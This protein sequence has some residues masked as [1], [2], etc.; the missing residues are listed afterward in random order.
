MAGGKKKKKKSG[1]SLFLQLW[2]TFSSC[3]YAGRQFGYW[4]A[5]QRTADAQCCADIV[6]LQSIARETCYFIFPLVSLITFHDV[7][8]YFNPFP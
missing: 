7:S 5:G 3:V 6:H 4:V 2:K 1:D 8:H